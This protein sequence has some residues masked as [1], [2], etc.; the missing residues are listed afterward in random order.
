MS[1]TR[2]LTTDVATFSIETTFFRSMANSV[3]PFSVSIDQHV[4]LEPAL[5]T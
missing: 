3:K 1:Y 2:L 4:Y 5:S